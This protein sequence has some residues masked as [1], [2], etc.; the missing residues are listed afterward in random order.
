[1]AEKVNALEDAQQDKKFENG[2]TR[3]S[4]RYLKKMNLIAGCLHG[5]QFIMMLAVALAVERIGSF[6]LPLLL[7]FLF[8][9]INATALV[10]GQE[11]IGSINPGLFVPFFLGLSSFFHFLVISPCGWKIYIVD[12]DKG[13]NRFRWYEYAVSSSLMIWLIAMF[14]GV[15]D[16]ATL[17]LIA[18]VNASMNF[19]G[20]FTVNLHHLWT[21]SR[22]VVLIMVLILAGFTM[23]VIN[24]YTDKVQWE[25]FIFGCIAGILPW[26]VIL[27]YF[28]G[29]PSVVEPPAF[30]Y[31]IVFCYFF[32]FNTFPVNMVLQYAKIGR[33]ADYRY[34]ELWYII[35]SLT[36][37]TLLAWIVLGGTAQ[38]Q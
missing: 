24:Q 37:K 18:G 5:V 14:F 6:E 33:W 22:F 13:I 25:S 8:F 36:S 30:V 35:L 27:M 34:G 31:A 11:N 28:L 21:Y 15:Y 10:N 16:L 29:G 17:I 1:M 20:K 32:F 3:I 19:F 12:L 38:P 26:V 9:D 7:N 2:E 4:F 23:E